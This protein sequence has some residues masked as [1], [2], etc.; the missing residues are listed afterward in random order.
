MKL[1]VNNA[2]VPTKKP[3]TPAEY[4]KAIPLSSRAGFKE[5]HQ[6]ITKAAPNAI[7][8]M[9]YGMLSLKLNGLVV[10]YA[11]HKEHYGLYPMPATIIEFKD[12][13]FKYEYSKGAIKFNHGSPLPKKLISDIVKY[14]VKQKSSKA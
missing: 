2:S 11:C 3:S 13:L 5:L 7:Q 4:I 10:C 9:T 12:K 14:R 1:V 6:I 8:G